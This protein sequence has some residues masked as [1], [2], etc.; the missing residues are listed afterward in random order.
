MI[1]NL[2]VSHFIFFL[3]FL[4]ASHV[5]SKPQFSK[6][7]IQVGKRKVVVELA[8]TPE[9]SAYGLM[10]RRVLGENE[11]M[12]FVFPYEQKLSF[13]M[14]N[15][16]VDLSIGFFDKEKRLIEIRDMKAAKSEMQSQ[17]E[18]HESSRLAQYAL[19]MRLGWFV[20]N[21]IKVGDK[22]TVFKKK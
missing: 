5:L 9:R 8:D 17:F 6:I 12:L 11:G 19:E 18:T 20:R 15:T 7:E 10:H 16:F 21:N 4:F 14:K 3:G 22:L 2:R 13:W 1:W